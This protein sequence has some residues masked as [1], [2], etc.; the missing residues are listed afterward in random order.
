M[1]RSAL[2]SILVLLS[3]VLAALPAPLA[4]QDPA[5]K[6]PLRLPAEPQ[7]L[8]QPAAEPAQ[9][10][11]E[12]VWHQLASPPTGANFTRFDGVFVAGPQPWGNKIYFLGGRNGSSTEGPDIWTFD[13]ET[14]IWTDTGFDIVEDVSNYTANLVN[15]DGTGRGPAIYM[16][17]GYDAD[18]TVLNI[19][20]V[21][22]F[23]PQVGVA[24][25]LPAADD[26]TVTVAGE[27][28]A[29]MGQAVVDDIIYVFGGWEN[30][31]EP[32]F[33][34]STW[35][36]DPTQP[37]GSRWTNLGIDLLPARSYIQVAVQNGKIYAMGGIDQYVSGDLVPTTDVKVLDTA[38]LAAGWTSVASMPVASGE[39]R[40]F[41]FDSDT[42]APAPWD[43]HIYLAGGGDWNGRSAESMEYQPG[44]DSWD[45][46]FADLNQAR[47]D[48]A[49]VF[50][51]LCTADPDDG[52]PGLWVFGGNISSDAGPF[53]DPEYYPLDCASTCNVMLVDD[54]WDRG[55][56]GTP[57]P[58]GRP[59]YTTALDGLGLSYSVW[60]T[61]SQGTP[62]AAQMAAY[63]V[64]VWFT[65]YDWETPVSPTEEVEMIGYLQGGG[66]VLLSDQEQ[67]Y[68]FGIT[69]LL[70]DYF[71]VDTIVDDVTLRDP[72]GNAADPLFA[73]LGPYT[74]ERPDL[75]Y[76]YWPTQ[77]YEG[78]YDDEVYVKAGGF[79]PLI[80]A[81]SGNPNSTRFDGGTFKTIYL[82]WPFEWL[83]NLTDRE[84]LLDRAITWL[85]PSEVPPSIQLNPPAQSGSGMVGTAVPYTLTIVNNIGAEDSFDLTYTSAWPISGPP[86][87]GPVPDGAT[88]DFTVTVTV[89]EGL[90]CYEK[91]LASVFAQAQAMPI[92]SDTAYIETSAE[93]PDVVNVVGT[94]YDANTGLTIPDAYA[95][96]ELGDLSYETHSGL[97]GTY[98]LPDV[99]ACTYL[100][101]FEAFGY[102]G[103][104]ST[105]TITPGGT[106]TLDAE[107][108]AS[109]PGLVPDAVSVA[110]PP[111]STRTV[112][113][114][115]SNAGTGE[116]TFHV[117]ELPA[118][119]LYPLA[120]ESLPSGIDP[121]VYTD[122][123]AAPDGTGRFIVYLKDQA[124]LSAAFGMQDWTARGWYVLNTLRSTA[125]R[126]QAAL[127]AELTKIGAPYESR[128]I[129]NALTVDGNIALVESIAAR[130]DVQYVGANTA[131]P[132]PAPV[133]ITPSTDGPE[134][135]GWNIT[136][137]KASAVWTDFADTG[138]GIVI[139]GIDTGIE[140]DHPAL[141][142]QY[143]GNLG[144]S[145][146]HDHNWWDP[147]GHFPDYP[148]DIH[149]HG[150]HTMGTMLG[151]DLP[152]DPLNA[153]HGIGMAPGARWI[154]CSGLETTT[155]VG[156]AADLI[157]CAEFIMAP[158]DLNGDDPDPSLRADV[159]NNS[160]G[161]GQAQFW[162]AQA[163]YAW[164]AAGIFP[165]FSNGNEGSSC[166]TAGDPG[167]SANVM[168]AGA[169]DIADHIAP[170]S[171]RGPA[172]VTGILKPNVSAPGVDIESSI[173]GGGYQ[174][175]WNGTSMASPHVAGEAA[176]IWSA[177]PELRGNVQLTYWLI[178]QTAVGLTTTQEC[179]GIPGTEIPNNT[180]GW[181]R[182]DAYGAVNMALSAPWDITWLTVDPVNGVVPPA[183]T[184]VIALTFD[185]TG[186]TLGEC[187]TGTLKVEY[188]DPYVTEEFVPV[189][190]CVGNVRVYLPLV[191]KVYP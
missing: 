123:K 138:E 178:E 154:G 87:V 174:G 22:R 116:L 129:V 55:S 48:H 63:D 146:S 72:T 60:D 137:V 38:N 112:N 140:Y 4:A 74:M 86:A 106:N 177:V 117:S 35:A 97:D 185:T 68:A 73:D 16:I 125:E 67:N 127:K 82:G 150:T 108:T 56:A 17:G 13:P 167:D 9:A 111:T 170:F 7:R 184:Q 14:H 3:L 8:P 190:M 42:K 96:L 109:R 49:G 99:P 95:Y 113:L 151:S 41:G 188:N 161:G 171:S 103:I 50:V 102:W 33:S 121:Q 166:G 15:D 147:Y 110:V 27:L 136:K 176:L 118:D 144:G 79:E 135:L 105:V 134:A 156:Y 189:E 46:T 25:T 26:W 186:L 24:E 181:G 39:G 78:P 12:Q 100:S 131:I 153:L 2:L 179:G 162:Y 139:A 126:S 84:A 158:W 187:Y 159:V 141:V 133:E 145:F 61:I 122:L 175:G 11:P 70:S 157:E 119:G 93:P 47:R 81:S 29:A 182:I 65:G 71:W 36:F 104:S 30:V 128:Y 23:Y 32:Y 169:T 10:A 40:G 83:P 90:N 114:L 94:I 66:N 62:T 58:G 152:S 148:G 57:N 191:F 101:Q 51:P 91:D 183:A 173:P 164:R 69:P 160:W 75:W 53:G 6:P 5:I 130:P 52:L 168:S 85:C 19:G 43:G 20:T 143:R 124:D 88:L 163:I 54:D 28:V 80:Y 120:R 37:S 31:T 21:Q 45:Q 142:N 92:Y 89:P 115:L 1:K 149:G 180:F 34:S 165:S 76:T 172:A 59:Y 107:L 98:L 132:A 18:N 64:V 155:G 44:P 77:T